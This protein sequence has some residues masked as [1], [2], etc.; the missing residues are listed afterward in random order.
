ML[1]KAKKIVVVIDITLVKNLIG[2]LVK[3]PDSDCIR[4]VGMALELVLERGS[5]YKVMHR[6]TTSKWDIEMNGVI[7]N[8]ALEEIYRRVYSDVTNLIPSY[9]EYC[10]CYVDIR[11]KLAEIHIENGEES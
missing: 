8:N 3:I 9:I 11:G 4:L 10:D 5:L 6:Y 2:L 1:I 7:I